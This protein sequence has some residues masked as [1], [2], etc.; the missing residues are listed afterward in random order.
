VEDQLHAVVFLVAEG[1]AQIGPSTP[2]MPF[3][4][5]QIAFFA[6]PAVFYVRFLRGAYGDSVTNHFEKKI[7]CRYLLKRCGNN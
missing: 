7:H 1:L 4:M 2:T 3:S 6:I 5:A